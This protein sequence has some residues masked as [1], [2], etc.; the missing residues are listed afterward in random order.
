MVSSSVKENIILAITPTFGGVC[1]ML[2]YIILNFVF[3]LFFV[4]VFGLITHTSMNAPHQKLHTSQGI[5]R[6][7]RR[8]TNRISEGYE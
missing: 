8:P 7:K 5:F 2:L 1:G 3:G 4:L 6:N